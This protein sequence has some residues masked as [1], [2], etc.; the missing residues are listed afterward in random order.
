MPK[1]LQ[2]ANDGAT[3]ATALL[4]AVVGNATKANRGLLPRYICI[5]T[6]HHHRLCR[7][8]QVVV[9]STATPVCMDGGR[10]IG[11]EGWVNTRGA[12]ASVTSRRFLW[13]RHGGWTIDG[14]AACQCGRRESWEDDDVRSSSTAFDQGGRLRSPLSDGC[15]LGD[16]GSGM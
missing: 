3:M 13:Q 12:A 14:A 9:A 11:E 4:L 2:R 6:V 10:H 7:N 15:Q 5:A 8:R 1:L 16:R